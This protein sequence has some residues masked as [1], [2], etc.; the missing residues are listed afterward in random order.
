MKEVFRR[1]LNGKSSK[2]CSAFFGFGGLV[3][4]FVLGFGRIMLVKLVELS[5]LRCFAL[6]C[7]VALS[8]LVGL[9]VICVVFMLCL[10]GLVDHVYHVCFCFAC[11]TF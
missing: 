7:F 9:C 10:C 4:G 3:L 8:C 2:R 6:G 11:F 1:G 5:L